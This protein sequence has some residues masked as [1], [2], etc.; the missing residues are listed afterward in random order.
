[1]LTALGDSRTSRFRLQHL[2]YAGII[3][4]CRRNDFRQFFAIDYQLDLIGVEHFAFEQRQGNSDQ[5]VVVRSKNALRCFVSLADESL[6]LVIDLDC[7][8]FT[9]I[10]MLVNLSTEEYLLFL[11]AKG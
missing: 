10:T 9:V 3:S 4:V 11:F 5:C 6:H 8:S 2:L 7:R 1:M